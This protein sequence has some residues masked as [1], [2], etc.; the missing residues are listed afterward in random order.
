VASAAA[1]FLLALAFAVGTAL[2][3]RR[4]AAQRDQARLERSI[5][6]RERDNAEA[7]TRLLEEAFLETDPYEGGAADRTA[8]DI[9]DRGAEIARTELEGS[10]PVRATLMTTLGRVYRGQGLYAESEEMLRSAFEMRREAAAG[11]AAVAES[12]R[13][14][15]V[16]RGDQGSYAEAERFARQALA[17]QPATDDPVNAG[18]TLRLLADIVRRLGRADE[19]AGL[20]EEALELH[21]RHLGE[22]H[23]EVA[24]DLYVLAISRIDGYDLPGASEAAEK[25]LAMRRRIP[26]T[27][28]LHL[29]RFINVLASC[30]WLSGRTDDAEALFREVVALRREQ[31]E[32]DHPSLAAPLTNLANVL[33]LRGDHAEAEPLLR[34]AVELLERALG[35]SHPDLARSLSMLGGSFTAQGRLGEA[36]EV[37][38]RALAMQRELLGE[39][40]I[41]TLHTL[42][43]LTE[44]LVDRGELTAALALQ[45]RALEL[46][47]E[48]LAGE[49]L[50]VASSWLWIAVCLQALGRPGEAEPAF[51]GALAAAAHSVGE[52][53]WFLSRIRIELAELYV[54]TG[55]LELALPMAESAV[56]RLLEARPAGHR[57]HWHAALGESILGWVR[58][59]AGRTGGVEELLERSYETL[60][61]LRGPAARV[62]RDAQRRLQE[63]VG[64]GRSVGT[65]Q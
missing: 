7:V 54:A 26:T 61:T 31:L 62:T 32:P 17:E 1:V 57:G 63:V 29:T 41:Y 25:A 60:R 22:E 3:A 35:P 8:R 6:Q 47:E 51:E 2:Q 39:S 46:R 65:E 27:N 49:G 58:L 20:A 59:R 14:L 48:T 24:D 10:S 12:L 50:E 52:D 19:A 44:V 4:T 18:R 16:L 64:S 45:R 13:E 11:G 5:A 36:E 9:L 15:A 55:R 30:H 33:T 40:H 53:H 21:R 43:Q 42:D 28:P 38:R 56:E 34:E 23:E 37:I